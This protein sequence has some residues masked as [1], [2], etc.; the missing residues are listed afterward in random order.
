MKKFCLQLLIITFLSS[1]SLSQPSTS[2][3]Y[4]NVALEDGSV[5]PGVS[6]ILTGKDIGKK[7]TITSD[8]GHFRFLK[9]YPGNYELRFELDGFNTL[10][11]KDIRISAGKDVNLS[12]QMQSAQNKKT[13]R[14][15]NGCMA[16]FLG[17]CSGYGGISNYILLSAAR[18]DNRRRRGNW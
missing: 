10:V 11:Q 14:I 4:G 7:T 15:V 3:I 16:C 5:L 6:I 9:L 1:L 13:K 2:D 12:V 18:I 8:E 17:V